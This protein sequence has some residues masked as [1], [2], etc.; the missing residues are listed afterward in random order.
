M[1]E[2]MQRHKK[3]L[4]IT[5]WIS[6]IAFVG[7]GF[8]GWG[9]YDFGKSSDTV[10]KVGDVEITSEELNQEYGRLYSLYAQLSQ[11]EFDQAKAKEMGLV[12][13]AFQTLVSNAYLRNY[14]TDNDLLV[15]EQEVANEIAKMQYFQTDG[16]FDKS[17]YISVLKANS[18]K[19]TFF[20]TSVKNELLVR[21]LGEFLKPGLTTLEKESI[22]APLY[23]SDNLSISIIN[24]NDYTPNPDENQTK[25]YWEENKDLFLTNPA[26]KIEAV[27]I[28][29]EDL[30]VDEDEKRR[31]YEGN[32]D[33]YTNDSG[34]VLTFEDANQTIIENIQKDRASK[35]I[36]LSYV[37]L[38]KGEA[39][40]SKELV[41]DLADQTYGDLLLE[42]LPTLKVGEAYKII[43]I[44]GGVMT[45]LLKETIE[46]K[47]LP[48][49]E[50]KEAARDRYISELKE[51]HL[52]SSAEDR[53]KNFEGKN[54]G[55]LSRG[56]IGKVSGLSEY[57]SA[58]FL[59]KLFDS[60]KDSDIV[61]LDE[62]AVVYKIMEQ[63]LLENNNTVGEAKFLVD[64]VREL[65][66]RLVEEELLKKLKKEYD[67]KVYVN[68]E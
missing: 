15:S 29:Y 12:E 2:W 46:P 56:E 24:K 9:S 18:I 10:A 13:Q 61:Y 38:K 64:S 47:P 55:F 45:F 4:V 43:E 23:V 14:A 17:K 50:A 67:L 31:E 30:V 11:G 33:K 1:I 6:T 52:I 22:T 68:F 41:I 49:D 32:L 35:D 25:A 57:E 19:P 63:K 27:S 44:P 21:K 60:T 39:N 26:F 59:N 51:Q 62:K 48:Y 42:V 5:I 3:Y 65:K 28:M 36:L 54:I 37:K 40:N 8:V 58:D 20:E 66:Y 34:E 7:A 53:L 16:V